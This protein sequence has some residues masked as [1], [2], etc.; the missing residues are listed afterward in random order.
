MYLRFSSS[1]IPPVEPFSLIG[2][3][4][5]LL[6]FETLLGQANIFPSSS[7]AV[8]SG[9]IKKFLNVES[10]P[11]DVRMMSWA[12]NWEHDGCAHLKLYNLLQLKYCWIIVLEVIVWSSEKNCS[13]ASDPTNV[14]VCSVTQASIKW[15]FTIYY[16]PLFIWVFKIRIDSI[17]LQPEGFCCSVDN[18]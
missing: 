7:F 16:E 15:H 13:V 11:V 9:P 5:N 6:C 8:V 1:V 12:L 10:F 18:I 14:Y 3:S 2:T 4:F 17:Y